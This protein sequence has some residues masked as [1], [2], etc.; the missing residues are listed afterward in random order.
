MAETDPQHER[1]D[2]KTPLGMVVQSIEWRL[3]EEE[4]EVARA[5][6]RLQGLHP[7]PAQR[8]E[9][10]KECAEIGVHVQRYRTNL[11]DLAAAAAAPDDVTAT[12][13]LRASDRLWV[14]FTEEERA[15]PRA[16]AEAHIRAMLARWGQD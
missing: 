8:A 6:N 11:A 13:W 16:A 14:G 10:L 4:E 2:G 5:L 1:V 9:V 7:D 15:H 12:I 3:R